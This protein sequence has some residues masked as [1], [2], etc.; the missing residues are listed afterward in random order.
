MIKL[1][2]ETALSILFANT[3]RKKRNEDLLTIARA[4]EYLIDLYGSQKELAKKIGLSTEMIREFRTVLKLPDEVQKLVANRKIDSL[5]VVREIS[6]I[7]DRHKQ[8]GLAEA[9]ASSS[10][11]DIR[12]I[13][14]L[15][16]G[17]NFSVS[18]AKKAVLDAKPKGWHIFIM[19]F[20][21]ET[22]RTITKL[23]RARKVKPA[24]L[25]R[26]IVTDWL[27]REQIK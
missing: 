19:D 11:K 21:D 9:F 26:K 8:I 6:V 5:D 27:K 2:E 4:C 12:D 24:E 7:K 1:D 15:V 23:A 25:V 10:T 14:R 17:A 3:K 13:K 22:Y 16:K 20:D 18:N